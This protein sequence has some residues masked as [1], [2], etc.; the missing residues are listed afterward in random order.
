MENRREACRLLLLLQTYTC[1]SQDMPMYDPIQMLYSGSTPLEP[2][3]GA[4]R[5]H[6]AEPHTRQINAKNQT[7]S[8]KVGTTLVLPWVTLG[9]ISI[10]TDRDTRF[11]HPTCR[12]VSIL[13]DQRPQTYIYRYRVLLHTHLS[14]IGP[15]LLSLPRN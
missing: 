15:K 2:T 5:I 3:A 14:D 13:L 1:M 9:G 10:V 12:D 7:C 11:C 8:G 4:F 6:P